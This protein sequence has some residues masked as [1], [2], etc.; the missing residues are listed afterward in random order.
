M[1]PRDSF[2]EKENNYEYIL[3]YSTRTLKGFM[4]SKPSKVNQDNY[5]IYPHIGR[6]AFSH[7]FT[8]CDGHGSNGHL[9]SS[10]IKNGF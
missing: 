4:S 7:F 3:R 8:V 5:L 2:T 1:S 9:V 10:L 6:K